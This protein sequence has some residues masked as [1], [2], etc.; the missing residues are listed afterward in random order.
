MDE[1]KSTW[2]EPVEGTD[3]QVYKK[4]LREGDGELASD[5]CT[6]NV[7]YV[8]TLLDGTKFDSSRDRPGNFSFELGQGRVIKGWDT[9][10]ATM[11]K[12]E[13][14]VLTC[15]PEYAYGKRGSP[16][17]I[18]AD[19]TLQFEVELLDFAIPAWK[20]TLEQKIEKAGEAKD[21]G[22]KKF[23]EKKFKEA[24]SSYDKGL[25]FLETADGETD[26]QVETIKTIKLGCLLNG[27]LM[28][29]KLGQWKESIPLCNQALELDE[30]NTK[31]LY[32]RG[33]AEQNTGELDL[34]KATLLAAAKLDPKNKDARVALQSVKDA[35]AEEKKRTKG[36]FGGMFDK[37]GSMYDDK[38][39]IVHAEPWSGPLPQVFFDI[40]IGDKAIGR[41]KMQLRADIAP[42]TC[43]NFRQ[44]C[45]G[46][47]GNGETTG[48]PLHYKG[49]LF[50]RVIK[51]FMLQGG[52]FSARNGTGG[53]S[54]YGAKFDDECFDLK[55]DK[56]G[57]LSM[58]N[59]GPGTNGSQ[60]FITTV[61]TPHLDGKHVVFGE[62]LE[63][64]DVVEHIENTSTAAQDKPIADVII[65]DCGE[66]LG[67][68][69]VEEGQTGNGST[70]ESKE[71]C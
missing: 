10:V 40:S 54:I 21:E 43:E 17:T 50:H 20:L 38:P 5:G 49:C 67:D 22:N 61:P 4:V 60:F 45:T 59:S 62:V 51:G 27:A 42:R 68:D 71:S 2:G 57:L 36:T 19:A 3:E 58:A 33:L 56:P 29:H 44:L 26:E 8:G 52:D 23:K 64:M 39:T 9:G 24:K 66:L 55:H 1:D 46:E 14:A 47:A 41:I 63:G 31:A 48:K 30:G 13:L 34:A 15:L 7:H 53:E 11:K 32:R 18:P 35:I 28:L 6:V 37:M 16:P 65:D 12:G 25:D 70:C 69:R